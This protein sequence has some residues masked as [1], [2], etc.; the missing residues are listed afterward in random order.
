MLSWLAQQASAF[1][2][3]PAPIATIKVR[4]RSALGPAEAARVEALV[5]DITPDGRDAHV[6]LKVIAS[7]ADVVTGSAVVSLRG[8]TP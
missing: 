3:V 7:E 4:F 2:A 6:S 8:V 5:R 1:A